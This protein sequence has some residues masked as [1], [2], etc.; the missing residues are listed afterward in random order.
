MMMWH[1][2]I[3][4]D[5]SRQSDRQAD[6]KLLQQVANKLL[7]SKQSRKLASRQASKSTKLE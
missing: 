5:R 2:G 4:V 6:Y 1:F 3:K 7:A